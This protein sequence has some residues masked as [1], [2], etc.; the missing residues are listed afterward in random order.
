MVSL[1]LSGFSSNI[2]TLQ[3]NTLIFILMIE[4]GDS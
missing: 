2:D 4:Q 1:D 3:K